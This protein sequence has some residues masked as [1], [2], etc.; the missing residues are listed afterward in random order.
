MCVV[1]VE[2]MKR[3]VPSLSVHRHCDLRSSENCCTMSVFGKGRSLQ[4][5]YGMYSR[6]SIHPS[7]QGSSLSQAS[8]DPHI[9]QEAL[10]GDD[11]SN[12][13]RWD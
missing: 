7:H 10:R 5:I 11:V 1:V 4:K 8:S 2:V 3:S 12:N 9:V 13:R 6:S